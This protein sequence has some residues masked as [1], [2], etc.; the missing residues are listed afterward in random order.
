[1]QQQWWMAGVWGAV[2]AALLG[3][4]AAP[5]PDTVTPPALAP[6]LASAPAQRAVVED[7]L[8]GGEWEVTY[9]ARVAQLRRPVPRLRFE[10]LQ[11][12]SGD[13]GCIQFRGRLRAQAQG[14]RLEGL[15]PTKV[16]CVGHA[17][18]QQDQ[19]FLA[20]ERTRALRMHTDEL[21]L[22]DE[23]GQVLMGLRRRP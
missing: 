13:E 3:G 18:G 6:V 17:S 14:V 15:K 4:C 23:Q 5:P 19:F 20:L 2:A 8:L 12:L 1:M 9:I 21:Q 10:G 22:L 7:E 16:S 11:Q